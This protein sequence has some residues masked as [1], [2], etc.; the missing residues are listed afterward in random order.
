MKRYCFYYEMTKT[1]TFDGFPGY[2]CTSC[3]HLVNCYVMKKKEEKEEKEEECY[4]KEEYPFSCDPCI[5]E[6]YGRHLDSL[7]LQL[8]C[9]QVHQGCNQCQWHQ[10]FKS[11][12][13]SMIYGQ[14]ILR[15]A[16][17]AD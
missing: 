3:G 16:K 5:I 17:E 9:D 12:S 13:V 15:Q 4:C 6:I 8:W 14:V 2:H 1:F 7:L 11:R 10:T